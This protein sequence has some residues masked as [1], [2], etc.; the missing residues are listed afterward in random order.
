MRVEWTGFLTPTETG[1][2]TVG[3]RLEGGFAA[4]Q[5][6]GRPLAAGWAGGDDGSRGRKSGTF[7]SSRGRRCTSELVMGKAAPAL[8]GRS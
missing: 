5:F 7:T 4:S 8:C 6:D 1:D 3:V 2:Y